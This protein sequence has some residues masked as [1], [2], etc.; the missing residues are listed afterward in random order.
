M[1]NNSVI[2]HLIKRMKS[3]TTLHELTQLVGGILDIGLNTSLDDGSSVDAPESSSDIISSLVITGL[4]TIEDA[5]AGELTFLAN[6]KYARFV[7]TTGASCILVARDFVR[8]SYVRTPFLRV[9]DPY[10]AFLLALKYFYPE[11][12]YASGVHPTAVI[13][14]SAQ[15]DNS[16]TIGANVVVGENCVIGAGVVLRPGVILYDGVSIGTASVVHSRV[17]CYERTEIGKRCIVHAGAVLGADGF[18]FAEQTDKSFQKIP[19]VGNVVVGDDVE[20]GANSTIDRATLG[21]TQ[22]MNGVKLDNLVH[23]AHN[24]VIGD[25]TAIAAQTGISGSTHLGKHNRI[26]GQVGFVGHIR[27]ADDVVVYAQSG[28]AKSIDEKGVYFGAPTK[29]LM[30]EL[31]L[32]GSLKQLPTLVNDVRQLKSRQ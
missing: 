32:Q 6:P 14:K 3:S 15:I 19:Q 2:V 28:V 4:N 24:V 10:N 1:P 11:T 31:R 20:I 18:G 26:A 8:S 23:V 7:E 30:E 27:T 9:D 12:V 5:G 22:I 17:V 13:A 29:P 25:H 16:A 21:S